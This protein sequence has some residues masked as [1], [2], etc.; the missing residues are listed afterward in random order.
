MTNGHKSTKRK[1][2][3]GKRLKNAITQ[4]FSLL[5]IGRR[6]NYWSKLGH[7]DSPNLLIKLASADCGAV[8]THTTSGFSFKRGVLNWGQEVNQRD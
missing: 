7:W 4:R 3:V 8:S 5:M 1:S 2:G 6:F